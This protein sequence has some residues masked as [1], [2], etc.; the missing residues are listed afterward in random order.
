MK[1]CEYI[2][3]SLGI[4]V[5]RKEVEYFKKNIEKLKLILVEKKDKGVAMLQESFCLPKNYR[6]LR[7][8]SSI[9]SSGYTSL[10]SYEIIDE[11]LES[12]YLNT[13]K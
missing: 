3:Q 9:Q 13:N 11:L 8:L 7:L 5:V 1:S 4:E 6:M 10:L 2:Q 12:R